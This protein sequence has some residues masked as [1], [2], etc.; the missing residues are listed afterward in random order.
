[1]HSREHRGVSQALGDRERTQDL[2][3]RFIAPAELLEAGTLG[4]L[5]ARGE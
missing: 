2:L 4:D 1:M 3:L 5:D